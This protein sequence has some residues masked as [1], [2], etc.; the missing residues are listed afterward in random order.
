[1][2]VQTKL[3]G[4]YIHCCVVNPYL[5]P[6]AILNL[7]D[8]RLGPCWHVTLSVVELVSRIVGV[9]T[10]LGSQ[11]GRKLGRDIPHDQHSQLPSTQ[12]GALSLVLRVVLSSCEPR[13]K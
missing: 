5:W 12:P 4:Q 13:S 2:A 1:M 3:S 7:I 9:D 11:P 6:G 8:Q 10:E